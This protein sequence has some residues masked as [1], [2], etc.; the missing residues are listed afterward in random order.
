LQY[1]RG[2]GVEQ[3]MAKAVEL[4]M[5]AHQMGHAGA[6]Y[7]LGVQYECGGVV[8][9]DHEMAVELYEQAH[10]AGYTAATYSLGLKYERGEGVRQNK[11]MAFELYRQAHAAGHAGATAELRREY[12]A[13][14]KYYDEP[15]GAAKRIKIKASKSKTKAVELCQPAHNAVEGKPVKASTFRIFRWLLGR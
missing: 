1:E 2:E 10:E 9:Q 13:L 7:H 5:Q 3:D 12:L 4:Y 15:R 6:S 8:E 14:L 11:E